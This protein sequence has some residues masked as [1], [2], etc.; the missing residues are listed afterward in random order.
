MGCLNLVRVREFQRKVRRV[1]WTEFANPKMITQPE[2]PLERE[3]ELYPQGI[4]KS[5]SCRGVLMEEVGVRDCLLW[6][7]G[8]GPE[9]EGGGSFLLRGCSIRRGN[10]ICESQISSDSSRLW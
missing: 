8:I 10:L 2:S 7:E 3:A 1:S 6:L 9:E 4:Q 5:V